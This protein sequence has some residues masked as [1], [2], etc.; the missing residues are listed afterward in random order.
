M[1]KTYA[2]T[3]ISVIIASIGTTLLMSRSPSQSI[4]DEGVHDKGVLSKA[5]PNTQAANNAV[6]NN[7]LPSQAEKLEDAPQANKAIPQADIDKF[8]ASKA[9]DSSA[10]FDNAFISDDVVSSSALRTVFGTQDF[11][12]VI[13]KIRTLDNDHTNVQNEENL[14]AQFSKLIGEKFY[15]ENYACSGKVCLIEFNYNGAEVAQVQLEK[16]RNFGSNHSFSSYSPS[17]NEDMIY[18]GLFIATDDPSTLTMSRD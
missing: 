11:S 18:R 12:R 2:F 5:Q 17:D 13:E 15:A 8:L 10:N 16:M 4:T 6:I 14:Y 9:F 1:N 7:E 3:I